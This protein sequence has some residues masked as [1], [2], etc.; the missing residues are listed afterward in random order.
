MPRNL[1]RHTLGEKKAIAQE[2]FAAP[3]LL[4]S[5]AKKYNVDL[6]SIKRWRRFLD[7]EKLPSEAKAYRPDQSGRLSGGQEVYDHLQHYFEVER[8]RSVPVSISMLVFEARR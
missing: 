5:T 4:Y 7:I 2:A 8:A 6:R 1:V 3:K